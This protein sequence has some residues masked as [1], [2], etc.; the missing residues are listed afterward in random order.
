[1][2]MTCVQASLCRLRGSLRHHTPQQTRGHNPPQNIP[3]PWFR[4]RSRPVRHQ[5]DDISLS[6][7]TTPAERQAGLAA[8]G[9]KIPERPVPDR[10]AGLRAV[11]AGA[12][13][14]AHKR[15]LLAYFG[16]IMGYI[17][18]LLIVERLPSRP[19]TRD[20]PLFSK[21]GWALKHKLPKPFRTP[22]SQWSAYSQGPTCRRWLLGSS[23]SRS[24]L[25][26]RG[27]T[28][29][30][31]G[32]YLSL[33][34]PSILRSVLKGTSI[35]IQKKCTCAPR[36]ICCLE[37]PEAGSDLSHFICSFRQTSTHLQPPSRCLHAILHAV[38][39]APGPSLS[40]IKFDEQSGWFQAGRGSGFSQFA[41]FGYPRLL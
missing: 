8:E 34:L 22:E 35:P 4:A 15:S 9:K 41:P 20:S 5:K 7:Y 16:T 11:C 3:D 32:T 30:I 31:S 17:N 14:P 12:S 40:F 24:P 39:L 6:G 26:R 1:M 18:P 25:L 10:A 27:Q 29:P 28:T 13:V 33:Q 21:E 38:H 36:W 19:A 23:S 2:R 37:D